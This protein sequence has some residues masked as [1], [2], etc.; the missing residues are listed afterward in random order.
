[1]VSRRSVASVIV[2]AGLPVLALLYLVALTSIRGGLCDPAIG[3]FVVQQPWLIVLHVA[4]GLG[5]LF[6]GS[7]A[8]VAGVTVRAGVAAT[9]AGMAWFGPDL[10]RLVR[11]GRK[12]RHD[13]LAELTER[14]REVLGL[15]AEGLSNRAIAERL[16]VAERTVESHMTQI[17]S[18]LGLEETRDQH[19]RVLAVLTLLRT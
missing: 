4:A 9:L 2:R 6:A 19:R 17:F 3:P 10:A 11:L 5:L 18:K 13:P 16:V 15:V 14:E 7:V 1:M 8:L 12:R